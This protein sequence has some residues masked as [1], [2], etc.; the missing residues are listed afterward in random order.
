MVGSLTSTPTVLGAPR[1]GEPEELVARLA[2]KLRVARDRLYLTTGATESNLDALVYL[3]RESSRRTGR[4]P[5]LRSGVPEY[6]PLFETPGV[7]GFRRVGPREAAEVAVMSRPNNPTGRL[8]ASEEIDRF[9]RGTKALVVDETF[10]EF[11]NA[12]SLAGEGRPGVWVVGS[13]TK[14][15]GAD[16]VRVGCL[17]PPPEE[18]GRFRRFA[19]YALH[20]IAAASVGGA[21]TILDHRNAILRESRGLFRANLAVLRSRVRGVP[22]L[23]APVWFDRGE[24]VLPGD[25]LARRALDAGVLVCSGSFFGDPTGVRVTLTRR[26]FP[27]DLAAYL[28]VRERFL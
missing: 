13:F 10:R 26:S 12:P 3:H 20:E 18:V 1:S 14:V 6:P 15:Y 19:E 25:T 22:G 5:R 23:A 17:V 2:Q 21:L 7:L 8:A 24:S 9:A 4:V 11:T 27:E 28:T 16:A